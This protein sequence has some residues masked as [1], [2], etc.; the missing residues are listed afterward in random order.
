MHA[1]GRLAAVLASGA[2]ALPA[3]VARVA[4]D[5]VAKSATVT[6]AAPCADAPAHPEWIFCDDFESAAPTVGVGRYF[7]IDD[8]DG[9]FERAAGVGRD[10]SL[11][12][13]TMWQ[14]G[15]VGAGGLKVAFGRNPN[16]YMNR[17]R[18]RPDEDF[19]E[20][21]Y[22]LDVRHDV[23]WAGDP[24]KLSRA[25]VFTH[26]SDWRQ[27]MVAHLWGDG[28]NHLLVDPARCVDAAGRVKCTTYNDFASLEWLG[29]RPGTTAVFDTANSGRW[30]CVVHHVR[31]NDPGQANGVQEFFIDGRLEARRDGLD[32][33]RG[34]RDFALNAVFVEN[35][36]NDGSVK[37]QERYF[38]NLVI[39]AGPIACPAAEGEGAATSTSTA[40]ATI[41]PTATTA[42]TATMDAAATA[43]PTS[44]VNDSI[45]LLP[46]VV[47]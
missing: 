30:Y 4:A 10:G 15:E 8:D 24:A 34:Y 33:V 31:L 21:W 38:D 42:S 9:E 26:A 23:G 14:Q 22:R 44:V 28:K 29:Y 11:G 6:A 27:A 20:I 37:A 45:A 5:G 17:S 16:G 1:P 12:M 7:E 13:R 19:R 43:V 46:W 3:I 35:Y 2:L 47:R 25:T 32:F 40:T 41:D 18:I 39:S 36:W